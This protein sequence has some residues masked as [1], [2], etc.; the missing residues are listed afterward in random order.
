MRFCSSERLSCHRY[1]Q[2]CHMN[3][4][5][6]MLFNKHRSLAH[7]KPLWSGRGSSKHSTAK[8]G[9][10]L[11]GCSLC[12][13][14]KVTKSIWNKHTRPLM[15]LGAAVLHWTR[16]DCQDGCFHTMEKFR[17]SQYQS[18]QHANGP[19][20]PE[21]VNVPQQNTSFNDRMET[22]LLFHFR[23]VYKMDQ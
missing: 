13:G 3:M 17:M 14:G 20:R 23:S 22:V 1:H 7:K 10:Y 2:H 4:R 9:Y 6:L 16:D 12:V 21:L 8:W 19:N 18:I 15:Y 11:W 5:G